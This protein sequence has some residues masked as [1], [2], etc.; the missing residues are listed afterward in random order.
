MINGEGVEGC[1]LGARISFNLTPSNWRGS[2]ITPGAPSPCYSRYQAAGVAARQDEKAAIGAAPPYSAAI[3]V[4][5]D[6][7]WTDTHKIQFLFNLQVQTVG[8]AV[9][10]N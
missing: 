1:R 4:L 5:V 10:T 7:P 8:G 6:A 2:G 9:A 3:A